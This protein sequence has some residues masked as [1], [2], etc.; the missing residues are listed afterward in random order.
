M[1]KIYKLINLDNKQVI[2]VG[3]TKNTLGKRRSGHIKYMESLGITNFGIKLIEETD[4]A[5][6]ERY[7]IE[8]LRN[9]GHTLLNKHKGNGLDLKEY[10][11]QYREKNKEY[12]KE[13][14]QKNKIK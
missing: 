6:R 8:S 9:E 2:Y 14:Y 1:I 4:D 5:S 11:K 13:Y 10:Q 7:W 3:I 12:Y